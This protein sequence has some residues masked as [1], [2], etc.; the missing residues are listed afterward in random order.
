MSKSK[1]SDAPVK[2]P[3]SCLLPL[4][5]ENSINPLLI[6]YI[7]VE[8]SIRNTQTIRSD[9]LTSLFILL[10]YFSTDAHPFS[11]MSEN[12]VSD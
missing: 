1:H 6:S 11:A 7:V 2:V 10:A 9:D 5:A 12:G 3:L 8:L 4:L